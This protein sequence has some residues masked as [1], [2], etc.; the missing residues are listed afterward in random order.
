MGVGAEG[1]DAAGVGSGSSAAIPPAATALES[2]AGVA[3]TPAVPDLRFSFSAFLTA[4]ASS[5]S[6]FMRS[7]S[8]SLSCSVD[9]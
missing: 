1:L 8:S 7:F 3:M 5:F 2:A 9:C 4:F 6:S